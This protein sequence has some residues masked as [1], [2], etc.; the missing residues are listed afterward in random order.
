MRRRVILFLLWVCAATCLPAQDGLQVAAL[1]D[2]RYRKSP[3]V[4]EVM[5][6][7]KKVR[8]YGLTLFRSLTLPVHTVDVSYVESLVKSDGAKAGDK[9]VGMKGRRLYYG[10]YGLSPKGNL[11]RYIFYRNN[12]LQTGKKPVLTIIYMEGTATIAELKARFGK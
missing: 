12:S 2:G 6:Q 1:F 5:L 4:I 11:N 8:P 10:F 7:G 3:D 9:E